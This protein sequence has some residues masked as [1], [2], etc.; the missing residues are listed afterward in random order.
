MPDP[1]VRPRVCCKCGKDLAG[2][3][4]Y[5]DSVGYWCEA[6]HYAGNLEKKTNHVPCDQ[7]GRYVEPDKLTPYENIRICSRC[8]R[9]R[10]SQSRKIRRPVVLGS[11]HRAQERRRLVNLVLLAGLLAL[12]IILAS[13]GLL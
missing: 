6:C 1:V 7:C 5:R 4:R 11:E 12:I 9:E 3:K 13:A 2:K 10:Q 8:L